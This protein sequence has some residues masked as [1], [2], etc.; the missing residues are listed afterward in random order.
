MIALQLEQKALRCQGDLCVN[1]LPPN[2]SGRNG[3]VSVYHQA[4]KRHKES[5]P[6]FLQRGRVA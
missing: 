1:W 3:L 6:Y 5:D 4:R 2:L